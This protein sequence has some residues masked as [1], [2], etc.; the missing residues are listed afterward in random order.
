[1]AVSGHE[2]DPAAL[3][4]ADELALV[5]H[6]LALGGTMEQIEAARGSLGDLAL[7]LTL[8]PERPSTLAQVAAAAGIDW[9]AAERLVTAIGLPADPDEPLTAGEAAAAG[10][11]IA[12][13]RDLFGEAATVQFARVAGNAVAR[14][15]EAM[16]STFRVN[17]EL[18]QLNRGTSRLEVVNGYSDIAETVLPAFVATLD[19]L[20]R[21]QIVIVARRMWSTDEEQS[22]MTMSRTVGFVDLV[23]YTAAASTMSVRELTSVLV[24]FDEQTADA[25]V[26]G[27]GRIVK[28]IG[29]EAMFV[30]EDAADACQIGL[31][32][33]RAFDSGP[34]PPVRV[35]LATGEVVSVFGDVYGHE[36]NLAARLVTAADPSTVVASERVRAGVGDRFAFVPI[37]DLSLKGFPQPVPAYRVQA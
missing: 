34:L 35:G 22:A 27:N 24:Q 12:V 28:T 5:R 2:P 17:V 1:M 7:D 25:V 18:P 3:D 33:V 15:A 37:G 10:L 19:A 4:A 20:L 9:R 13:S 29:D 23:G 21:R 11:L 26:R 32:L 30:T 31:A 8:R 6:V 36:V 14:I 16:V